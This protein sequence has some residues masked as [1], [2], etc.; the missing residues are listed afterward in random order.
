LTAVAFYDDTDALLKSVH[1]TYDAF[2]RLIGKAVDDDGDTFVDRGQSFVY[3]G[4]D[5]VL[6]YDE[7]GSLT[8][9]FLT[10]PDID[11]MLAQENGSGDVQWLLADQQGTIRDVAEYDSGTETTSVVNHLQYDSFGRITHIM[12]QAD[13]S[14]IEHGRPT[15]TRERR[16]VQLASCCLQIV[17]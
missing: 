6:V 5:I 13:Q 1:Y 12:L 16:K 17:T 4:T 2:D 9:R 7:T 10:G 8:D 11:Q 3:D 14:G 15:R